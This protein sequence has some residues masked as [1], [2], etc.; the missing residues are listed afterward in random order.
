MITR[1]DEKDF[2]CFIVIMFLFCLMMIGCSIK[3]DRAVDNYTEK[4]YQ[5]VLA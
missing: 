5:G 3:A 4:L 2:V 1:E